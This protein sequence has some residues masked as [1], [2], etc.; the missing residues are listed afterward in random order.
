MLLSEL[1]E[2]LD[3]YLQVSKIA[4]SSLNGLQV[5]GKQEIGKIALAVD[6]SVEAVKRAAEKNA[7]CLLFIT[8]F[9]GALPGR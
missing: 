1:V 7:I 6:I 5:S 4:D 3:E 9:S 8:D 2:Y